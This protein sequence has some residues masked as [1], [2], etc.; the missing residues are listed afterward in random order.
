MG[1]VVLYSRV[2]THEQ[3][4][5]IQLKAAEAAGYKVD[6]HLADEGV[7]GMSTRLDE[8]PQG[9]NLWLIL[10]EGDVLLV[11]WL[12][13]ISRNLDHCEAVIREF[14]GRGVTVK[15]LTNSMTFCGSTKDPIQRAV[16]FSILSFM[17]AIGEAQYEATRQAQ[18]AG[19]EHA[20][21]QE[22][23]YLGRRPTFRTDQF[24]AIQEM[25][26]AGTGVSEIAKQVGV[27][28]QVVYRIARQPEAC[29]A[30]LERWKL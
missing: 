11:R 16:T 13:R 28:R 14:M 17:A 19:I 10:R 15:T 7:S 1:Q 25:L 24:L 18:A 27:S 9:R 26:T 20:K 8:R 12:D 5:A 23:K 22:G 29:A 4:A 30:A 3:T 21:L 2:S 6:L